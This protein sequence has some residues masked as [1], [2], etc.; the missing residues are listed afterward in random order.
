MGVQELG[1]EMNLQR[2]LGDPSMKQN[3]PGVCVHCFWSAYVISPDL[4]TSKGP[5]YETSLLNQ[6]EFSFCVSNFFIFIFFF[7][8]TASA[9][10]SQTCTVWP[11]VILSKPCKCWGYRQE[12]LCPIS[13][14][15]TLMLG[16]PLQNAVGKGWSWC[17]PSNV[18]GEWT[19]LIDDLFIHTG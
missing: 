7:F 11:Q 19:L 8:E 1:W 5:Q 15:P 12:L 2:G 10:V 18:G 9:C 4:I 14:Q 3:L 17:R 6:C 16:C 13:Q